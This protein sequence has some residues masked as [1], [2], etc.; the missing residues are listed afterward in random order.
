M[1]KITPAEI[2]QRL[3][4]MLGGGMLHEKKGARKAQLKVS[5]SPE[6]MQRIA[7]LQQRVNTDDPAVVLRYALALLDNVLM[8]FDEGRVLIARDRSGDRRDVVIKVPD[9]EEQE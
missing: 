1:K 2:K 5:I 7:T 3:L 6:S 8:Q 4:D 9:S